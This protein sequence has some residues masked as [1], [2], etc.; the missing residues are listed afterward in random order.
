MCLNVF[1]EQNTASIP[2]KY[3]KTPFYL[4]ALCQH[5]IKWIQSIILTSRNIYL[6][7]V[8]SFTVKASAG[9]IH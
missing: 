9:N 6:S 1:S 8:R 3:I 7:L 5:V 4:D 2:P